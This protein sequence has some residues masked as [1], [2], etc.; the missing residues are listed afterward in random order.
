MG[1]VSLMNSISDGKAV[2]QCSE[3]CGTSF[4]FAVIQVSAES[5]K[6][7]TTIKACISVALRASL[8]E[9]IGGYL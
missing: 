4:Y 6:H 1:N 2:L 9:G 3:C 7:P 8:G 5:A